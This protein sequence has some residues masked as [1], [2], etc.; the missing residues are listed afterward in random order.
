MREP[1]ILFN[2]AMVRAILA[3]EKTQTRRLCKDMNAWVDQSCR[4]VRHVDGVPH[5]FLLGAETPRG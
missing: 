1:P 3:G 4:E 2:G 5:H